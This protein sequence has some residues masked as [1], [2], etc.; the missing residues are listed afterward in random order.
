MP[1]RVVAAAVLC[2]PQPLEMK[3]KREKVQ[4]L[5][6]TATLTPAVKRLMEAEA[7]PPTRFLQSNDA[8][9]SLPNMKHVM[10]DT[11]G[12][13]KVGLSAACESHATISRAWGSEA[14][15]P[16]VWTGP[17]ADRR[18]VREPA[19]GR[20]RDGLLQHGQQLQG[21][22]ARSQGGRRRRR[23]AHE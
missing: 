12:T 10:L 4:Y 7:F 2:P 16:C 18:A 23:Q 20:A 21:R 19:Q 6:S 17:D 11:K 13:D 22:G 15:V 8:H 1:D 5:M 3:S 9:K 14:R